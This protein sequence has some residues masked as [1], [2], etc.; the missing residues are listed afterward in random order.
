MLEQLG[1]ARASILD[2]IQ[3]DASSGFNW[4][5]WVPQSWL[6]GSDLTQMPIADSDP[7]KILLGWLRANLQI[8]PVRD[9]SMVKVGF[10]SS[11]PRLAARVAN[12]FTRAY[13]DYNLKQ[14]V[15]ST[16][17]ASRWLEE[18]LEKSQQ[19]VMDSVDTLQ[20]YRE[21]AGL[22]DVEGMHSVHT[23]QLKDRAADLSEA[24]RVRSEAEGLYQRAKRLRKLGQMDA[25]PA[26]LENP[27]IQRLRDEEQELERQIRA[28]SER[29]QGNY[30]GLDDSRS[31]LQAVREQI[32]EALDKLIEGFKTDYQI[33]RAN[34]E[35]L[36]AEVTAL[37]ASVQELSRKQ[38]EAQALEQAVAT[39]SQSYDAFLNQLMATSTRSADTVSMIAR[40][41]DPAVAEF[42]PVKPNKRRML[43]MGLILA[44]MGGVGI[45]LMLDKFDNSLK[46]REDVEDRLGIPVLGELLLLQGKRADGAPFMPATE[47]QDEP[48]SSFAE[49]IRTIRTGIALSGL[50]QSQ[51]TLVITS[52]VSGEGKSTVA[53][54]LA[55]SLA[56]LGN[57][58]L[59]DADLRRPALAR[60]FGLDARTAGL[61]DL[62][63]G[64]AKVT[65]C[66]RKVPG[67]F[68]VLCA[69]S[70]APPD[71]LKVLSSQRF[72]EM[73]AK[74]AASYDTLVIDSPPVE[75]VSD[76]RVLATRASGV[77]YVIKAGETP[78]QAVRQGLGA[79]SDTGYGPAR[80]RIEPG[81]SPGGAQLRQVQIR[82]FPLRTRLRPLQ[83][84]TRPQD[85]GVLSFPA[86]DRYP[87]PYAPGDRRR[88][89][90][91]GRSPRHG[92]TG[93][94][95]RHQRGGGDPAHP[96]RTLRKHPGQRG[97]G[98]PPV[99]AMPA[100]PGH[101]PAPEHGGRDPNRTG[102]HGHGRGR[103][104]PLAG[105]PGRLP[106][107]AARIAPQP[108][109]AGE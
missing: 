33:A 54:N 73:L 86:H 80:R 23:E 89:R 50:D 66:I 94:H 83:L 37:E 30:P 43:M 109:S 77:V 53:L 57:V 101:R 4:R 46:S 10:D 20:Q 75:L 61:T 18:Q 102:T 55:L 13:I 11:D 35:R 42:T 103:P 76:A 47:F 85:P 68:H 90:G 12:A 17:E 79:L 52:T 26:V 31:N 105:P 36:Q 25:I 98:D 96:L 27:W 71:P 78:H 70:T 106:A 104:G 91:T 28:D 38:L 1:T 51:Q 108:H 97:A 67:D 21:E 15:E 62:V 8:Q 93:G 74:A 69:G 64:T 41:V 84:R 16:T 99:A 60:L 29:F 6:E 49:S 58:L 59:I 40:V 7:D 48:T 3:K 65:E 19:H 82:V 100:G 14:R 24:H 95:Q 5:D 87:L 34:E 44:L 22:V 9:T 92:K 107:G 2:R 88:P 81:Q 45:A 56:Q 32:D 72:S 39:N 63:A